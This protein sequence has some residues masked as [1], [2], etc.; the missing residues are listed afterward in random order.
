MFLVLHDCRKLVTDY[1]AD[2]INAVHGNLVWGTY[3]ENHHES[4][5]ERVEQ[6]GQQLIAGTFAR[7][8]GVSSLAGDPPPGSG[9]VRV[10]TLGNRV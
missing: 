5:K 6:L 2:R 1:L 4:K 9:P 3:H 10:K 8:W 7:R